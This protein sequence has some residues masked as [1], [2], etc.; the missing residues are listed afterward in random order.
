MCGVLSTIK[1]YTVFLFDRI[2][3]K[4]FTHITEEEEEL[5]G[6]TLGIMSLSHKKRQPV[7]N[8]LLTN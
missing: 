1:V 3:L 8:E 6:S 7:I 4:G 2:I 5:H